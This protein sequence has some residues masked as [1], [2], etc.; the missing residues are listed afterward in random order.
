[1]L[2]NSLTSFTNSPIFQNTRVVTP[3]ES[4]AAQKELDTVIKISTRIKNEAD[5]LKRKA[6]SLPE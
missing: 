2:D 1:L 3:D 6:K 4:S 5:R